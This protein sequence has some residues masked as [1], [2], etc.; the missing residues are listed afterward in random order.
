MNEPTHSQVGSH[1]GSWS[2]DGLLNLQRVIVGVKTHWI[3]EFFIS[4][5]TILRFRCLKW[6]CMIH[7]G[8]LKHK[9]WPKEGSK[10]K[11]PI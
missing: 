5:E 4:L 11:L 10:I 9:L 7:L 2:P 3:E 1:F 8:Y 6:A